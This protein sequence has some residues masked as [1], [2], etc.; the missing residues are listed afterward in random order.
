MKQRNSPDAQNQ[1]RSSHHYNTKDPALHLSPPA[2]MP[3][4]NDRMMMKPATINAS[5]AF[6]HLNQEAN[7]HW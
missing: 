6:E 4:V 2:I 1:S 7:Q 3:S 5:S